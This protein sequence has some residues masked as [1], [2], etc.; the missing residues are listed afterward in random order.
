MPDDSPPERFPALSPPAEEE[1]EEEEEEVTAEHLPT[2][3][4]EEERT[5]SESDR[6]G[7]FPRPERLLPSPDRSTPDILSPPTV[8]VP[9]HGVRQR[10][11]GPLP[12]ESESICA[13]GRELAYVQEGELLDAEDAFSPISVAHSNPS[14][15][16]RP[17]P[18]SEVIRSKNNQEVIHRKGSAEIIRRLSAADL[19]SL[20]STPSSLPV[21]VLSDS[22]SQPGMDSHSCSDAHT[23][24]SSDPRSLADAHLSPNNR[25]SLD[26]HNLPKAI[27]IP[28]DDPQ[29][30]PNSRHPQTR[31]GVRTLSSPPIWRQNSPSRSPTRRNSSTPQ[32]SHLNLP[33][34]DIA[35]CETLSF[36]TRP[37][38]AVVNPT[39]FIIPDLPSDVH[40]N[41]PKDQ[42]APALTLPIPPMSLPTHLELELAPE[43][44]SPLYIYRP[45]GT[46]DTSPYES[47][48]VKFQ[49]LLNMLLLP[50]FLERTLTFGVLSCL[51]AWLYT[52]TILPIRFLMALWLLVK[53][54][55]YVVIKECRWLVGFVWYGLGRLWTRRRAAA[56]CDEGAGMGRDHSPEKFRSQSPEKTQDDTLEKPR[57]RSPEKPQ[58]N[59]LR[60]IAHLNKRRGPL[61]FASNHSPAVTRSGASVFRHR[62]TKSMPSALSPF[63]KADLLQGAV[64]LFSCI[65]MMKMDASRMYH[66]I[67][68]QSDIK[69]YVIFNILEVGDRLLSALGQDIL[70][71]LFSSEM[72]SRNSQGRSKVLMPLGMFFLALVYTTAHAATLY[73]HAI[74]LN[75]AV[76][77]YSNALLTLLMSNQFVEVKSTVFKRFEK[78]NLFQ[79]TCA[80]IVERFQ[81]WVMLVIIGL[82]N[83]V[84][85]GGLSVPGPAGGFDEPRASTMP[86]HSPS[87]LPHSFTVL[88]S[89]LLSGEVLSPFVIVIASEVFVDAVK[90][91]YVSRF[92]SIKPGFYGRVLDILCKDY[93][94][95][96]FV[97]PT[98]PR[99]LGLAVIPLS[100]LFIRAS[101]QTYH[102]FLSTHVAPPLPPSTQTS[103]SQQSATPSPAILDAFNKFDS[104]IRD[105][106]GRAV[107]ADAPTRGWFRWTS[108]DAIAL[109]TMLVVFFII[110]LV[111]LIFKLLLGM[112]LLH[113]S[114]NRY[115]KMILQEERI[116]AGQAERDTFDAKSKRLGGYGHVEVGEE[117]KRWINVDP[118]E[119]LKKINKDKKWDKASDFAGVSRYEMVAKRIW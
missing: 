33:P 119:G 117:R 65:A 48:A 93:Y 111:A 114:R 101:I 66:F 115:G 45:S 31:R 47:S 64:I 8:F 19:T 71:C 14:K 13:K 40:V 82:R 95:D 106:L 18:S 105:S 73:F 69:L 37:H 94:T 6:P 68:G 98:L 24:P 20:A 75:V 92:N 44:P 76:N 23:S 91:A 67:R 113:Y 3:F 38:S 43:R 89:W 99:R 60:R 63:H 104:L 29:R 25:L 97:T 46:G 26:S 108:D 59:L 96:A 81:L 21:A 112:V 52:F 100:C 50:P 15:S 90:H 107:H 116:A 9:Y 61:S 2:I 88:P 85:M 27:S 42:G 5:S 4:S 16:I 102:M 83:V 34:L 58:S 77:A 1:E 12:K 51:D 36:P 80:D 57:D 70:E 22:N 7:V 39:A 79:L 78:D 41:G 32:A 55:A 56:T 110:F 87:I 28:V 86:I 10:G 72:L 62:R 53:W 103:L 35:N 17:K 118:T 49:R 84:E 30:P 11:S 74:T 54:W 109:L